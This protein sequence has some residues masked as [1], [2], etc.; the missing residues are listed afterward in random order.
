MIIKGYK[1]HEKQRLIHNAINQNAAK[2]TACNI[3]RQFGKS[4][5]AENQALY[6]AI[7]DKGSQIAWVAPIY[8][9]C[10]KVYAELKKATIKSG[11]FEYNDTDMLIRGFGSSIQFFSSER[12][13]NIRGNT[14]DYLI[15]DEFDFQKPGTWEEVLQPTVLVKGKK[16]LFISTPKG[17]GMM[18]KM[19]VNAQTDPRYQYFHFTSYDN[20]LIDPQ[21]IDSIKAN[22]PDHVF[23]QEYLA[24]FVD[25]GGGIFKF[26][27]D[28]VRHS[29]PTGTMY[30]GLDI[31]RADDYTVL[32]IGDKKG[33]AKIVERWR[34]DEWSN[35]VDKVAKVINDNKAN[36]Y[37]EVNNQGD[38]FYELLKKKCGNYV[39]PFVTNTQT[40]PIMIE[41]LA[42]AFEQKEIALPNHEWLIDE[43]ESYTFIYDN[44]TRRVKYGAPSG[45]HDDGVMSLALYDQAR[46]KLSLRG[47]YYA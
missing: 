8:K 39:Q 15:C 41:D 45:V 27:R 3:G 28:A 7:N 26:V 29:I 24:E 4:L 17:R 6:W 36:T 14:F 23:R 10:K 1:P 18:F 19:K 47:K 13:D 31:G 9:Q 43:C 21:E 2:Y 34:H 40:K 25:G 30:G 38:V 42:L 46:K 44:K 33:N 32:T 16:V 22:I 20:P 11:L 5:L 12:P 35:I 37:I